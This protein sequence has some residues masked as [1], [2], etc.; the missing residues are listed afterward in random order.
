MRCHVHRLVIS[1]TL[2]FFEGRARSQLLSV[3]IRIQ[4]DRQVS[5]VLTIFLPQHGC[6]RPCALPLAAMLHCSQLGCCSSPKKQTGRS[7]GRVLYVVTV[8]N[9]L[10][11]RHVEV[12]VAA[13]QLALVA[14]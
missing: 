3:G 10:L 14:L 13:S 9:C 2:P 12:L 7:P 6:M 1:W 5:V 11:S 4:N 8:V